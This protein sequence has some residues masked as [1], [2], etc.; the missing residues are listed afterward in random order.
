MAKQVKS[1]LWGFKRE[2]AAW[3]GL[4]EAILT[5]AGAFGFALSAAETVALMGVVKVFGTL[6]VRQNVYAPV[7]SEGNPVE[8]EG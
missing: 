7:D 6:F 8:M 2:P 4:V 5:A 3:I 1:S